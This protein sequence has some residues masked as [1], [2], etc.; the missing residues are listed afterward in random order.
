MS[1]RLRQGVR[2]LLKSSAWVHVSDGSDLRCGLRKPGIV[3]AVNNESL[4]GLL[5]IFLLLGRFLLCSTQ[6]SLVE[7]KRRRRKEHIQKSI[8]S[9]S[10]CSGE[11]G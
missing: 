1:R 11:Y 10:S 7:R 2:D 5:E 3:V 6:V 9:V 4:A 8:A